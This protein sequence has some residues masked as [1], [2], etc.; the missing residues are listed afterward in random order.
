MVRIHIHKYMEK[1]KTL[2][3]LN[4]K[5]WYRALKVIY[6]LFA[7]FCYLVA[8]G[9]V[10]GFSLIT[11][12][13]YGDYKN[14]ESIYRK[15]L[16]DQELDRLGLLLKEKLTSQQGFDFS[17]F[18]T[19]IYPEKPEKPNFLLQIF[20]LIVLV[21]WSLFCAWIATKI[22]RWIFYYVYFGKVSL[23]K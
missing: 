8:L 11:Y 20:G 4:T 18:G 2:T 13:K 15:G 6:I 14:S 19:P 23:E 21:P 9:S 22:P 1:I 12:N 5:A 3:Y 7:I 10:V 17:Q 16:T